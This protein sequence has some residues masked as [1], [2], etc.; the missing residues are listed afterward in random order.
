MV[1]TLIPSGQLAD[2]ILPDADLDINRRSR[3]RLDDDLITA[4]NP[5][6]IDQIP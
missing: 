3:V 4:V 6:N 1:F 5:K 2:P